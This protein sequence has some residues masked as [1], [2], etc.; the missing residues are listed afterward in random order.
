M[1]SLNGSINKSGKKQDPTRTTNS[2]FDVS[3]KK[4]R[5]TSGKTR[6]PKFNTVGY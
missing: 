3:D 1:M 4:K 2:M 5:A 6:N